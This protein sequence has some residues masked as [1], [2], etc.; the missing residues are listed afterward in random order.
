MSVY[1][2][3]SADLQWFEVPENTALGQEVTQ[4]DQD[5]RRV[6]RRV[7]GK[8]WSWLHR[9]HT[10]F[11]VHDQIRR[12]LVELRGEDAVAKAEAITPTYDYDPP[13]LHFPHPQPN[14]TEMK[15]T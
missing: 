8:W 5:C 7:S 10:G 3:A 11:L 9:M 15:C 1:I 13:H 2:Y 4:G 12:R 14:A 6:Y